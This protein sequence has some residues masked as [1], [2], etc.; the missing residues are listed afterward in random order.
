MGRSKV[1]LRF[2]MLE[3]EGKR[4]EGEGEDATFKPCL[5]THY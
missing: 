3:R 2:V 1:T 4:I 5:D